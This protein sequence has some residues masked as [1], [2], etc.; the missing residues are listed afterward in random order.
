[1]CESVR[2]DD[3]DAK[4]HG[5]HGATQVRTRFFAMNAVDRALSQPFSNPNTACDCRLDLL[6]SCFVTEERWDSAEWKPG[7]EV[8]EVHH[9]YS[10]FDVLV[11]TLRS[12]AA[13]PLERVY[14]YIE[15]DKSFSSRRNE[16][17]TLTRSLFGA[18]PRGVIKTSRVE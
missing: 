13:L 18:R 11:Y 17:R 15:L 3:F 12:Y 9:R 4:F 6:M 5:A 2:V 10:R 14:L 16:L 7:H 1:M 8:Y